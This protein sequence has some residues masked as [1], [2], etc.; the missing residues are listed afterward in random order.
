[1]TL[2]A[3]IPL[4]SGLGSSDAFPGSALGKLH[5]T[6]SFACRLCVHKNGEFATGCVN[7]HRNEESWQRQVNSM[8]L[9]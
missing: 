9:K 1:M 7:Q 4:A 6:E 3:L 8:A 2:Q 5:F